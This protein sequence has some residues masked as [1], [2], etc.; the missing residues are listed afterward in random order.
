MGCLKASTSTASARWGTFTTHDD[1][2]LRRSAA[3]N[4]YAIFERACADHDGAE[5]KNVGPV[6][7]RGKSGVAHNYQLH[8]PVLSV[9]VSNSTALPPQARPQSPQLSS[10]GYSILFR[11]GPRL[12]RVLIVRVV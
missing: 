11:T 7:K 6:A 8:V 5:R 4:S 1:W 12:A 9:L 2:R 10:I 3:R